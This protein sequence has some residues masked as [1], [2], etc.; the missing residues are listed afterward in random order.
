MTDPRLEPDY[1]E[2]DYDDDRADQAAQRY[3]SDYYRQGE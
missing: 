2:P 1:G 3:E